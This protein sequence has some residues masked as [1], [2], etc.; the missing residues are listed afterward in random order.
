MPS[1]RE[2]R[3][4]M[5]DIGV[6]DTLPTDRT[7]DY[8]LRVLEPTEETAPLPNTK[9]ALPPVEESTPTAPIAFDNKLFKDAVAMLSNKKMSG[10]ELMTTLANQTLNNM[11]IKGITPEELTSSAAFK[12]YMTKRI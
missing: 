5:A 2:R 1:Y 7:A 3:S 12:Q 4:Q 11:N 9:F 10:Y 8:T 6:K